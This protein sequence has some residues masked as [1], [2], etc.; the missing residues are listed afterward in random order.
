MKI[1]DGPW[2]E[3]VD[4]RGRP[5]IYDA[6]GDPVVQVLASRIDLT[7]RPYEK[8]RA[9]GHLIAAAPQMFEALENIENDDGRIPPAIWKLRNDALAKARGFE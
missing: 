9:I 1:F 5:R 4:M 3:G 7:R 6:Y 8:R 2:Q